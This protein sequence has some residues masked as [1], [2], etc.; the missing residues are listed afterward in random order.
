MDGL[1]P[2]REVRQDA[3]AARRVKR[4]PRLPKHL[5]PTPAFRAQKRAEIRAALEAVDRVRWGCAYLPDGERLVTKAAAAL[6][7]LRVKCRRDN[8]GR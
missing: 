4:R 7:E 3:Q 5:G 2:V 1:R 8:W 6:A